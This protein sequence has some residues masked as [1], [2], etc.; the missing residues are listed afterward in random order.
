VRRSK[1]GTLRGSNVGG[2]SHL[3]RS[4][5]PPP[6]PRA[7]PRHRAATVARRRSV[8]PGPSGARPGGPGTRF[9]GSAGRRRRQRQQGRSTPTGDQA[10]GRTGA[11]GGSAASPS[12]ARSRRTAWGSVTARIRRNRPASRGPSPSPPAVAGPRAFLSPLRVPRSTPSEEHHPLRCCVHEA[13]RRGSLFDCRRRRTIMRRASTR[14]RRR[15]PH[16][17][18]SHATRQDAS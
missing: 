5:P 6:P 11:G 1:S 14:A 8:R 10:A 15:P 13:E 17:E 2:A 18:K 12:T 7:A 4:P 16:M 9:S 3:S